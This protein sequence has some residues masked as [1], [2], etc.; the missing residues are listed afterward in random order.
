MKLL[1]TF[2]SFVTEDDKA[3][4]AAFEAAMIQR[5]QKEGYKFSDM[6]YE[7]FLCQ[8]AVANLSEEI[9]K[10]KAPKKAK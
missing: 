4:R 5:I 10:L 9:T 7:L 8:V 3:Q 6:L 1:D 2:Q